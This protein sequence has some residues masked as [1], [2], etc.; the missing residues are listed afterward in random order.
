VTTPSPDD[1]LV[2][3][4]SDMTA[5]AL[6][7]DTRPGRFRRAATPLDESRRHRLTDLREQIELGDYEVDADQVA[8]AILLS[9]RTRATNRLMRSRTT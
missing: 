4:L 9:A 2:T 7:Y 6:R 1:P 3:M 5:L 8:E